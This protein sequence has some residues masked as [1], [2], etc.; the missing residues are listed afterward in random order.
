MDAFFPT[1][2]RPAHDRADHNAKKN[3]V[4][5]SWFRHRQIFAHLF[6]HVAKMSLSEKESDERKAG[7]NRH[8]DGFAGVPAHRL[9][10][11]AGR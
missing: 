9:G 10:R 1:P 7:A 8:L 4:E 11:L 3:D 2:S 5:R 6:R